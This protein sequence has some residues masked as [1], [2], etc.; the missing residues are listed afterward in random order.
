[1]LSRTIVQNALED[2]VEPDIYQR[3]EEC[4]EIGSVVGWSSEVREDGLIVITGE[5]SKSTIN[6]G[7]RQL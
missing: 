6:A 4:Y 7:Q 2:L 3:G 5:W 1:M